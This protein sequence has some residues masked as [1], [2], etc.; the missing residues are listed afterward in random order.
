VGGRLDGCPFESCESTEEIEV[1]GVAVG[2][3]VGSGWLA[4]VAAAAA[5]AGIYVWR[6]YVVPA[7]PPRDVRPPHE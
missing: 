6:S 4:A 1:V 3:L 5:L 2:A 7:R